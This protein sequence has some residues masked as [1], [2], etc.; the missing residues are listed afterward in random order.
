MKNLDLHKTPRLFIETDLA[1]GFSVSLQN[2]QAHYLQNVL[3]LRTG[4]NLRLF[5]GRD[6]EFSA[7]LTKAVK[8]EIIVEVAKQIRLQPCRRKTCH[9][10]FAPLK[11]MR[12][13][14][15]IEKA[16]ELGVSDFCP[17]LTDRTEVRKINEAR[18]RAQSIE[19]AE[20][21][22]RLDVPEI[23][24]LESLTEKIQNWNHD[25]R[26]YVCLERE[27]APLLSEITFKKSAAFLIGPEGGFTEKERAFLLARK[28]VI[29]VSLGTQV[30]RAETSC[31]AALSYFFLT[32][33]KDSKKRL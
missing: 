24:T 28:N 32:A 6:G 1:P 4:D 12:M 23:H 16:T 21:S 10:L 13:D 8:K 14:M 11:K 5:N 26:L 31:I 2:Q 17:I 9:L 29:P 25:I 19:A 15:I 3:R 30:L 27:K 33:E 7:I 20:Q 22:E 18:L